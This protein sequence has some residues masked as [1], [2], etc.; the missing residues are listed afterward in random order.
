M[1]PCFYRR[2]LNESCRTRAQTVPLIEL[3][4]LR[5]AP[6]PLFKRLKTEKIRMDFRVIG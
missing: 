1:R 5:T 4:L 2:P 3:G 6:L